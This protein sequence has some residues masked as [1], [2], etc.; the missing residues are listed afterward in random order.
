M[1]SSQNLEKSEKS[2]GA[3]VALCMIFGMVGIHHFYLGNWLHGL[4]DLGMFVVGIGLIV[5]G[6]ETE[7]ALYG[8]ALL[9]LDFLHT[10]TVT[11]LLFIGKVKD[12]DGRLISYPG[13]F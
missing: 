6:A 2:Y 13:Q 1:N 10:M 4:I 8:F 12:G 11:I 3:A 5:V 9:A 7:L